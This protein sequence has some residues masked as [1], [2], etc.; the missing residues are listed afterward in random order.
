MNI[1]IFI[2]HFFP[3]SIRARLACLQL[4]PLLA[5]VLLG[6]VVLQSLWDYRRFAAEAEASA[7][8]AP[9][10]TQLV[11]SVDKMRSLRQEIHY[12]LARTSIK[13]SFALER[14]AKAKDF[15]RELLAFQQQCATYTHSLGSLEELQARNDPH[16]KIF[17]AMRVAL[18]EIQRGQENSEWYDETDALQKMEESLELLRTETE[19]LTKLLFEQLKIGAWE[20][21]QKYARL[22]FFVTAT[23]ILAS[24]AMLLMLALFSCWMTHPLRRIVNFAQRVAAGDF[25][26]RIDLQTQDEM[27]DIAAA[28]NAMTEEFQRIRDNLDLQVRQRTAE[29]LQNERLASVGFLAAGVAHEINNPLAAIAMCAESLQKSLAANEVSAD[30][31]NSANNS[32]DSKTL[33]YLRVIQDES[34]RCQGITERLLGLARAPAE[35]RREVRIASLIEEMIAV[36]TLQGKYQEKQIRCQIPS[37]LSSEI[38][39]QRE[40]TAQVNPQELKQVILNL[41]T[42]SCEATAADGII[43][44]ALASDSHNVKISVTDNG[45][46]MTAEVLKNVFEP[47]F[48]KNKSGQGTGLGL[49]I[50]HRIISDHGGS[51]TAASD[52]ENCGATFVI[53]LP[54]R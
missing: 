41:L 13:A 38:T 51:L 50:S 17:Q 29:A 31:K 8:V 49:S 5:V 19:R 7:S 10:L 34:F 26:H 11:R 15:A 27:A 18:V 1:T 47:F 54:K 28:M 43:E 21:Q 45:R 24:G 14:Q 2:S 52:G 35:N 44:V 3:R 20:T 12:S 46:G 23:L 37:Q 22:T 33:H 36:L 6:I 39:A 25:T 30:D 48:T 32:K 53:R 42:N 9:Q 4:L 16:L 40:I